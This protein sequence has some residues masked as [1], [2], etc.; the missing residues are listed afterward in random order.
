MQEEEIRSAAL[1][2]SKGSDLQRSEVVEH[3]LRVIASGED[4]TIPMH[5]G[6]IIRNEAGIDKAEQFF[7]NFV[8]RESLRS[9]ILF[10]LIYHFSV[11]GNPKKALDYIV[12]S[13]LERRLNPKQ[14]VF[15]AVQYA[16]LGIWEKAYSMLNEAAISQ[17]DIR[18]DCIANSQFFHFLRRFGEKEANELLRSVLAMFRQATTLEIE[19]D[20][21]SALED[22]RPYLLLRLGD[23]EGSCINID[24]ADDAK[25]DTYYRHNRIE[26]FEIW[27]RDKNVDSDTNF[28][29]VVDQFNNIILEADCIGGIYQEAIDEEY[30]IGSRRGIAWIVNAMRKVNEFGEANRDWAEKT[31]ICPLTI[32]YDL[33]LQGSLGRLLYKRKHVGLVSCHP[34][35]ADMLKTT[36]GIG[37]VEFYKIPGEKIHAEELGSAESEGQHWPNRFDDLCNIFDEGD[38]RGQLFLVAAGFLGKIYAAKLKRSGAVV[39]DIGAVADLWMGKKTRLFPSLPKEHALI[40]SQQWDGKDLSAKI[41]LVDVGGLGGINAHWDSCADMLLPIVFEPNPP[42]AAAIRPQIEAR[43]GKVIERALGDNAGDHLLKVTRSLG[44]TS[45]LQPNASFLKRYSI[46]PAFSI[47]HDVTISCVRYDWLFEQGEVP[48]PDVIKIDVQGFEFQVLAGFGNLLD[49]CLGVQLEAH[50]YP[51]YE[52]QKLL[53]DLVELLGRHGLVLRQMTPVDHFDGDLVEV[54]A[55]FTCDLERLKTLSE[56]E[57]QKL[58]IIESV[59]ALP[60]RRQVFHPEQ[61]MPYTEK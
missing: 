54:D 26:F 39:I 46:F 31:P 30:R 55:W 22:S 60:P 42:E 2:Y 34:R 49:K 52:G 5:I 61:F 21:R 50:L 23:G 11:S 53:Q 47:T 6:W 41:V 56:V 13:H 7:L 57:L 35:L 51:I 4:S 12:T 16:R 33:L 44:C 43:G 25:Y 9:W 48:A 20:I 8:G 59:W 58:G 28:D 37:S 3:I 17:P 27:F 32:H 38:R 10:E 45:L 18:K 1:L 29:L 15:C 14:L 40:T 19:Q 36:Y 24:L